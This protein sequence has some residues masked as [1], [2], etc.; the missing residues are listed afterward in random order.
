MKMTYGYEVQEGLDPMIELVEMAVQQ[1]SVSTAPGAFLVD[2]FPALRYVPSWFPGGKWKR[3]VS[4]WQK[5]LLDMVDIPYH[6]VT[7]RMVRS[8]IYASEHI[9]LTLCKKNNANTANFTS[10]LLETEELSPQ[11]EFNIKWAAASLY[12]GERR[13]RYSALLLRIDK[14]HQ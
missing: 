9:V 8:F 2:V 14:M 12:S 1:F 11:K 4:S 13:L 10:E 3:I 7:E 6:F 5:T